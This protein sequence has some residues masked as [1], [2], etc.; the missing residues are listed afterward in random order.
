[1][2]QCLIQSSS[3]KLLPAVDGNQHK[4]A[5]RTMCTEEE[6]LE[7]SVLNGISSSNHVAL[8]RGSGN[9]AEEEPER[10]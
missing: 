7:R 2:D 3:E 10:L 6:V 9:S 8:P 1:M 4:D 5:Q